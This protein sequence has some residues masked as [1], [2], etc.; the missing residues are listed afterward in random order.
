MFV[1]IVDCGG[2]L[3]GCLGFETMRQMKPP[4]RDIAK[5]SMP[6]GER[7][8][9]KDRRRRADRLVIFRL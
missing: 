8:P 3:P 5:A 2:I 4:S 1:E 9:I 6:A 7:D